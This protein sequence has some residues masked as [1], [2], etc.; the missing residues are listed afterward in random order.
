[1]SGIWQ[2]QPRGSCRRC[3]LRWSVEGDGLGALNITPEKIGLSQADEA[4]A[5]R[6]F[7]RIG[8]LANARV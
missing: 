6:S 5:R 1:M 3:Q 4:L 7:L 8:G 2:A